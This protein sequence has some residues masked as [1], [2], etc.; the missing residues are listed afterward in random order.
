MLTIMAATYQSYR[1]DIKL[2]L[3]EGEIAF[4]VVRRTPKKHRYYGHNTAL[5]AGCAKVT[6][7]GQPC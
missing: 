5:S 3:K 1:K 4:R 2:L 6:K 7:E